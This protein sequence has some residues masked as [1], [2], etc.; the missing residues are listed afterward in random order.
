MLQVV[1][2]KGPPDP[3]KPTATRCGRSSAA[4]QIGGDVD[5]SA[6]RTTQPEYMLR[7]GAALN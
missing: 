5:L 1:T 6:V 2:N 7:Q 4:C 3:S